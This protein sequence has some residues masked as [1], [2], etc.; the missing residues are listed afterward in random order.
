[1]D[2]MGLLLVQ[3]DQFPLTDSELARFFR[4]LRRMAQISWTLNRAADTDMVPSRFPFE[5]AAMSVASGFNAMGIRN[6]SSA[7]KNRGGQK[8][9]PVMKTLCQ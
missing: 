1:M 5:K 8:D 7:K 3:E 6:H 2:P 9:N 4:V